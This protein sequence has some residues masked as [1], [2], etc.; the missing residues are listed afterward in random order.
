MSVGPPTVPQL[1]VDLAA[2]R[3]VWRDRLHATGPDGVELRQDE[4]GGVPG[5]FPYENLVYVD[6]DDGAYT[7]TNVVLSGRELHERTFTATVTDGVLRFDHLGPEAPAHL[8][9][10]AGAGLIWFVAES[11]THEGVGR[12]A[13]PDLI[14]IEGDRRWRDTVLWRHGALARLLHV[15]GE[16][17]GRDTTTRHPLDPRGTE[18]PVHGERSVTTNYRSDPPAMATTADATAVAAARTGADR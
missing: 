6:L 9:V 14:R 15:E 10:S 5:A 13:E 3:G 7:Q 16:R 4:A 17:V 18:G 1:E 11:I 2:M 8:G 12:Y